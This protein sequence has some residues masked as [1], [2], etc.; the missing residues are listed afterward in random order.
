MQTDA[1][2]TED[3]QYRARLSGH[4]P[5]WH[6]VG[7]SKEGAAKTSEHTTVAPATRLAAVTG[8]DV[9]ITMRSCLQPTSARSRRCC[10]PRP[11]SIWTNWRCTSQAS[12]PEPCRLHRKCGQSRAWQWVKKTKQ[13]MNISI[14]WPF[15]HMARVMRFLMFTMIVADIGVSMAQGWATAKGRASSFSSRARTRASSS[16]PSK[17]DSQHFTQSVGSQV[18]TRSGTF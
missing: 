7:S 4:S 15:V 3:P 12:P 17:L 5:R 1:L 10:V 11:E 13:S 9:T 8:F 18:P 2:S 14:V 6:G 16:S